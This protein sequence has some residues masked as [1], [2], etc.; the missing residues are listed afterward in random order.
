MELHINEE[1]AS[2]ISKAWSSFARQMVDNCRKRKALTVKAPA[3]N[4]LKNI[5]YSITV[6]LGNVMLHNR[7]QSRIK[8][9]P[10]YICALYHKDMKLFFYR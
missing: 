1:L 5:D 9:N 7:L 3:P 8:Y 2:M 10:R 4:Q 6:Q